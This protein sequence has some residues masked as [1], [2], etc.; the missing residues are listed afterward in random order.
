MIQPTIRILHKCAHGKILIAAI[1]LL[2]VMS[3]MIGFYN[4]NS[5]EGVNPDSFRKNATDHD[6]APF[7]PTTSIQGSSTPNTIATNDHEHADQRDQ[8]EHDY[9]QGSTQLV[10]K[11]IARTLE[12]AKYLSISAPK[13]PSTEKPFHLSVLS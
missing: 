6:G 7:S 2:S 13:P 4:L 5:L 9:V 10:D 1:L 3:L 11:Y 12:F 8:H